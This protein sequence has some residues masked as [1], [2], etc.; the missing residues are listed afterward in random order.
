MKKIAWE[1]RQ[2]INRDRNKWENTGRDKG[3][4]NMV[5]VEEKKMDRTKYVKIEKE[6]RMLEH[7]KR[8]LE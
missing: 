3:E 2:R 6:L 4:R 5:E 8:W 1:L 7:V